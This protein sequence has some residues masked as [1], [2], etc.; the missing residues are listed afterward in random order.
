MTD[1][2]DVW[3]ICTR[4]PGHKW[5]KMAE[6]AIRADAEQLVADHKWL[7]SKVPCGHYAYKIEP[8][9]NHAEG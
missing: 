9:S 2:F 1:R 7:D 5:R 4:G 3:I 6:F 8:I